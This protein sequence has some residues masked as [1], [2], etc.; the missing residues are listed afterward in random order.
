MKS[1]SRYL[2]CVILAALL[3][4]PTVVF[5]LGCGSGSG[6]G[7]NILGD[8]PPGEDTC[9]DYGLM[10]ADLT[11]SVPLVFSGDAQASYFSDNALAWALTG[12]HTFTTDEA[13]LNIFFPFFV[14]ESLPVTK[15]LKI[16]T[17]GTG[18]ATLISPLVPNTLYTTNN[19]YTGTIT[20]QTYDLPSNQISGTFEFTAKSP[21][22]TDTVTVTSGTFDVPVCVRQR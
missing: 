6:G 10:T 18:F 2:Q 13:K 16:D 7:S 15:T 8:N 14:L 12:D 9:T 22:N 3:M 19:S 4:A 1:L 21:I 20:I 11:D 17:G 5:I